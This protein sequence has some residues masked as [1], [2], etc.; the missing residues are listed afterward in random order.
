MRAAH[1]AELKKVTILSAQIRI[2][3]CIYLVLVNLSQLHLH[4]YHETKGYCMLYHIHPVPHPAAASSR[5][6][7]RLMTGAEAIK[8][9]LHGHATFHGDQV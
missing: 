8:E 5:Q 1:V 7:S 3:K 4:L 9:M 2:E 6:G